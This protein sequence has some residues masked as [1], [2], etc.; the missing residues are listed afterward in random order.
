M[1]KTLWETMHLLKLILTSLFSSFRLA[2]NRVLRLQFVFFFYFWQLLRCRNIS[3]SDLFILPHYIRHTCN[4]VL[5]LQVFSTYFCSSS[6]FEVLLSY[7]LSSSSVVRLVCHFLKGLY[8]TLPCSYRRTC[9][10]LFFNN[11]FSP[12]CPAWKINFFYYFCR[13]VNRSV[14]PSVRCCWQC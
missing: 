13:H 7:E 1:F 3:L 2:N 5:H 14:C 12:E 6:L 10:P 8:V 4:I 9:L 11:Y